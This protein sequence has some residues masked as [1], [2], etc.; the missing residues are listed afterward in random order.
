MGVRLAYRGF[1]TNF[2]IEDRRKLS[3]ELEAQLVKVFEHTQFSQLHR[4]SYKMQQNRCINAC[5]F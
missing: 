2:R 5:I 4:I 1:H 3:F